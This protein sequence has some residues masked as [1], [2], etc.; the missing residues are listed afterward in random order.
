MAIEIKHY[1]SQAYYAENHNNDVESKDVRDSKGK[2]QDDAEHARPK[3]SVS[4]CVNNRFHR[5]V[6]I[7]EVFGTSPSWRAGQLLDLNVQAAPKS[8][9]RTAW[10]QILDVYGRAGSW[11]VHTIAH[12]CL[13][14]RVCC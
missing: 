8:G 5:K 1:Y 7:A 11:E 9:F 6:R 12:R 4:Y 13:V 2:A 10:G 14:K 3:A